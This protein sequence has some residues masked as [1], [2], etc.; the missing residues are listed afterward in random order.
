MELGKPMLM[1]W[2]KRRK[3]VETTEDNLYVRHE[4]DFDLTQLPPLGLFGEY[5]EMVMQFGFV[6]MFVA[7][8][9]LAPLLA[10]INNAIEIRIDAYKFTVECRRAIPQRE[11]DIG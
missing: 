9:P 6:T 10:L 4:K 11:P 8:F 1:N 2:W 7:A 5:F 3:N